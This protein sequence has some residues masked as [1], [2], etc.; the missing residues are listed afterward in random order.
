MHN[1]VLALALSKHEIPRVLPQ[2][3]DN[4][5]RIEKIP[6]IVDTNKKYD[7][8]SIEGAPPG[9]HLILL[10]ELV[11]GY[12]AIKIKLIINYKLY[13]FA[14]YASLIIPCRLPKSF[15]TI[16]TIAHLNLCDNQ[17]LYR[18]EI[19]KLLLDRL[20]SIKTIVD[21]K[22]KISS[23]YRNGSWEIIA[24]MASL[25]TIHREMGNKFY[26]DYENCYWNSRFQTERKLLVE[27]FREGEVVCDAFC[28]VGPVAVPVLKKKCVF[29][30]NDLNPK[31][32]ECLR[33][34]L[35]LNQL[36]DRCDIYNK[37]CIDQD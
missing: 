31:A 24:G 26:I 22:E 10:K 27:E 15:E 19:G 4:I 9:C 17:H 13:D 30:G 8:F 35:R 6:S 32:V 23:V 25:T 11:D 2:I 12:S 5:L 1:Y 7:M 14:K 28:G 18:K 29:F 3:S 36:S 16:G 34:N 37:G 21:K 20:P 33:I